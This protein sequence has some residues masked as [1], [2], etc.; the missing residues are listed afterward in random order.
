MISIWKKMKSRKFGKPYYK[1][2]LT[3]ESKWN[4]PNKN[5][6]LR[7][8][9]E[10]N[11]TFIIYIPDVY[12][13]KKNSESLEFSPTKINIGKDR[14]DDDQTLGD[15][16][17]ELIEGAYN[18]YLS[19]L[20]LPYKT[21][22][23]CGGQS[24]AYYCLAM[25]N[26]PIYN[27]DRAN[28]I[29][30]PHSKS[31]LITTYDKVY[32]ENRQYCER[33]M[34]KGIKLEDNVIIIDAIKSGV[35]I[36]A[37][38]SALT[39]CYPNIRVS[40]YSINDYHTIRVDRKFNFR[41]KAIF[42]DHFPRIVNHYPVH[43]FDDSTNFITNFINLD[44]PI[45]EMV[46]DIA[47]RYPEIKVEDTDWYQLNNIITPEIEAARIKRIESAR[48]LIEFEELEEKAFRERKLIESAK[49]PK[50]T[51]LSSASFEGV[52][53][54]IAWAPNEI[55]IEELEYARSKRRELASAAPTM[56]GL[57]SARSKRRE[58]ASAAPTMSGLGSAVS[59]MGGWRPDIW[60][61][62]A[63]KIDNW[64]FPS[65]S[66]M[67]SRVTRAPTMG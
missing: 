28:I 21:T 36:L 64:V 47:R 53:P 46:V 23:I 26:F 63:P 40:K 42:S 43:I 37:L 2:I 34:E 45:A 44:N 7:Q 3:N 4:V 60:I 1:N 10:S 39:Q 32:E 8:F 52:S 5:G 56:S 33:L 22:I 16:I 27:N 20:R 18:I 61:S 17:K 49:L 66:T 48:K 13:N 51:T 58:L 59:A 30:L 62:E 12:L 54:A 6:I 35:G 55:T 9:E 41:C 15:C 19:I 24:P 29:V 11:N 50:E 67:D 57:G 65:A 31:G 38:E 25:M 14:I